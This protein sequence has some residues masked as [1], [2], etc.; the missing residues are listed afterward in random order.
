[1]KQSKYY[2]EIQTDLKETGNK[3][4]PSYAI[5]LDKKKMKKL[6]IN[7]KGKIDVVVIQQ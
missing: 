3:D 7:P 6:N 5:P 1:M 4:N 2:I